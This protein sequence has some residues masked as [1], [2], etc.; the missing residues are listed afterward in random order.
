MANISDVMGLLQV[1]GLNKDT[2]KETVDDFLNKL[3][4]SN[5][6]KQSVISTLKSQGWFPDGNTPIQP[7]APIQST[8]FTSQ[9]S[10]VKYDFKKYYISIAVI[11]LII[12]IGGF[13][14]FAYVKKI[15]PFST[16]K[17][18]EE[19][20]FSGLLQKITEINSASYSFSGSINVSDRD[21]DAKPF[22]LEVSNADEL[23]KK[24]YYDSQRIKDASSIIST[25]NS[26]AG[27]YKYN[28]NK[29]L[30]QQ[31]SYPTSLNN[32]FDNNNNYNN[33]YYGNSSVIDPVTNKN[34]E[35]K[36]TDGGKNFLLTI[37]FETDHAI[38]AIRRQYGYIAT[39]TVIT[40]KKVSFT[41]DSSTYLYMSSEPPKPILVTL[42]ESMSMVPA[43]ISATASISA[44]SEIKSDN[45]TDWLF[46]VSA[47]GDFGDLT[48]KVNADAM[49]K[50]KNYYF[51][52]NNMPNL[53]FLGD[54]SLYKG[55]WIDV[56]S[57]I[58]T[59]TI[60][61]EYRYSYLSE[62]QTSIPEA[63]KEYKANRDKFV[64]LIKKAVSIADEEKL[65]RFKSNPSS[66]KID[67]RQLTRYEL[68]LKKEALLSFYKKLQQE[69]TNDPDFVK[70]DSIA[71]VGLV[72]YLQS[73]EFNQVFDY[74]DKNYNLVLWT[75]S[76]GFPAIIQNTMRIVPA[77]SAV[78][79]ANKQVN[80]IFKLTIDKINQSI[81]IET[82][83]DAVTIEKIMTDMKNITDPGRTKGNQASLKAN[84]S[85][86]R[87]QAEISYDSQTSYG[88]NP[89]ALGPCKKTANTLFADTNIA[90]SLETA[91]GNNISSATCVSKG[92][93]GKVSSYAVSVPMPGKSGFS[94]CI[95]SRGSSK[96]IIGAIKSDI[97]K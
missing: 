14:A 10:P 94:W 70:Y 50:N 95:D 13:T 84:L 7:E 96:E 67:G 75:D 2:P 74:V 30:N 91:T 33:Y 80:L 19:N 38:N 63:E 83:T 51:R 68:S 73:E 3:Q 89:F 9:P 77:D 4:Y 16:S 40:G 54:I 34:Y 15:G 35:Y 61:Y 88:K 76:S 1:N 6:D 92:T 48:Y 36:V 60:P 18:T 20:F 12:L 58:S 59:S 93:V 27:Y 29:T 90:K 86:M 81:N 66:E 37:N 49:K 26:Q 85:N 32:L 45:T 97:C 23:N 43:G 42:G 28:Y 78:Q 62:L 8:T 72:D 47:E 82:P 17:Y 39:T 24:Y 87:A 57:K 69:I 55:K 22:V 31:K 71:D 56:S 65:I 5:E 52:I 11:L 44:S 64:K 53:F 46:N 21:K 25:L 79:L 41:K